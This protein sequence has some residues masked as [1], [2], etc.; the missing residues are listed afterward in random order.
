MNV[1]ARS[2]EMS[3]KSSKNRS[4]VGVR[5]NP[6]VL[7]AIHGVSLSIDD[8]KRRIG[9]LLVAAIAEYLTYMI[10]FSISCT[11]PCL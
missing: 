4:L 5:V 2:L 9:C 6:R 1:K 8:L 10:A 11:S 3:A 7:I